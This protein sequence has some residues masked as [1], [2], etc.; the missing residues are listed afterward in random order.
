MPVILE[1]GALSASALAR[2]GSNATPEAEGIVARQPSALVPAD[3]QQG[4]G[5]GF[6]AKLQAGPATLEAGV[7]PVGFNRVN[8]EGALRLQGQVGDGTTAGVYVEREPVTDSVVSYA[9]TKD[10]VTG[11]VW[12][13][14]MRGQAGVTYAYAGNG[15]GVYA[16]LNGREYDGTAVERNYAGELNTGGYFSLLNTQAVNATVGINLNLQGYQN[17]Q[18]FFTYGQGGYFSPRSFAAIALPLRLSA[19]PG[20]WSFALNLSPGVQNFTEASAPVYPTLPAAQR[21]LNTLKLADSDVRSQFDS[22]GRSGFAMAGDAEASYALRLNT[23]L[24][25]G[26]DYNSFGGFNELQVHLT[27][28]QVIGDSGQ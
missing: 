21:Q 10:P 14:V 27:I 25:G 13:S 1:A 15:S 4:S 24:A 28:K 5:V 17:D 20:A 2:F 19:T 9:G 7:T 11:K 12:G 23:R 22:E 8:P 16:E 26:V 6:S 3:A 18:D